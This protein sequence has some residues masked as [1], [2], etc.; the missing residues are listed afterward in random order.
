MNK[1]R[2]LLVALVIAIIIGLLIYFWAKTPVKTITDNP[3]KE[4][5]P[6]TAQKTGIIEYLP[7]G[8]PA[9][10]DPEAAKRGEK[11]KFEP[12]PNQRKAFITAFLTPIA[13]WGKVTDETGK[14]ISGATVKLGA[15]NNPNPMGE[16]STYELSTDAAGLFSIKNIHGISLSVQV[17][18]DGY[19]STEQSRGKAN[20]VL[21]N[22]TDLPVP[23]A[24]NP[25]VFVLRKKG[26]AA[27]LKRAEGNINYQKSGVPVM[28]NLAT[29]KASTQGDVKLECWVQDE[30]IDTSVYNRYDWRCVISVPGGGLMERTDELNFTA[31]ADGYRSTDEIVMT[32][33]TPRWDSGAWKDY[34]IKRT[35]GTFGRVKILIATGASNFVRFES[36]L[37]PTPGDRN[38]QFDAALAVP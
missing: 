28:I 35:D 17:S 22:N 8:R 6:V 2:F 32:K 30:G 21:K 20:Y 16:G 13:F 4:V 19:Y 9:P 25:A 11:E 36:Y 29:G 24:D 3:I 18:K 26:E 38:L 12:D 23:T 34:F 33:T 37:N 27:A 10:V 1:E 31:P 5:T 14:P 7:D 15:N